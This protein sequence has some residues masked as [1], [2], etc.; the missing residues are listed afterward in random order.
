MRRIRVREVRYHSDK[1][2]WTVFVA[3]EMKHGP[4]TGWRDTQVKGVYVGCLLLCVSGDQIEVEA[5]KVE[6][7]AWGEQYRISSYHRIV[8][9]TILEIQQFL[10]NS[11]SGIGIAT[12]RHLTDRYGL[13]T[14]NV[15]RNDP[16]VLARLKLSAK[17]K[18]G[19]QKV[20]DQGSVFE[21]L[22]TFFRLHD[23][24]HRY[25]LPVYQAYGEYAMDKLLDNP[26]AAYLDDVVPFRLADQIAFQSHK[27]YNHP[28]RVA[29]A[30]L[31]AMRSESERGNVYVPRANLLSRTMRYLLR[32]KSPYNAIQPTEA[33]LDHALTELYGRR[34]L[35]ADGLG[36]GANIY[37]RVNLRAEN[38][39]AG[40]LLDVLHGGPK[41]T[42]YDKDDIL[43]VI[44]SL[45]GITLA[46]GQR[47]AVVT[48]LTSPISILTGGPG[49][50]K[51]QTVS[52]T[53]QV[54]QSLTPGVDIRLCAPTGKA[55]ARMSELAGME[56]STI[57]RLLGIGA[58]P[59]KELGVGELVC[60]FLVVDEFSMVDIQ[61]F[62]QLFRCISPSARVLLVGDNNQLPSVGPGLVLRDL[63]DSKLIPTTT[64][65]KVFRQAGGSNI[66]DNAHAIIN[67]K[68]GEALDLAFDDKPG[69]TFY[70]LPAES[71]SQV[72]RRMVAAGKRL[73]D[74]GIPLSQIQVLSPVRAGDVGTDTL[75]QLLQETFNP[76]GTIYEDGER[77]FR[78]GDKVIHNH[79]DYDLGVYNGE[80]GYILELGYTAQQALLVRYRDRDVWYDSLQVSELDL[81]YALTVHRCQG[82][83]YAAVIIPVHKTIVRN[84]SRPL[85]YTAITRAKRMVVLVGDKEALL[86]GA[87]RQ[88]ATRASKLVEKLT[89]TT[90]SATLL[91]A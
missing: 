35:I 36:P 38:H 10:V 42:Y 80:T 58:G 41:S 30:V 67:H 2:L 43:S 27:P 75:N 28:G 65:T 57:H 19:L 81:A 32:D 84:L 45:G 89:T 82:S 60:D 50:G 40:Y 31:A 69:G 78:V 72:K 52:A 61:L 71:P 3:T 11:T 34:L 55:A 87:Q 23:L 22:L 90:S 76:T 14:L 74:L 7:P 62:A 77:V 18:A 8:P 85:I 21:E 48:A 51:T 16:S 47:K 33:E 29:A 68:P 70:V 15:L 4:K 6:D 64:L 9:G 20:L 25:A 79:N 86:D 91:A 59:K 12:A 17:T 13:D 49:T 1:T 44:D 63:I 46:P 26:Y 88:G 37:E 54:I 24:D 39:G 66:V 83:E 73:L 56:A 5:E 53:L